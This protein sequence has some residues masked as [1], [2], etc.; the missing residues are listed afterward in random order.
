MN[1]TLCIGNATYKVDIHYNKTMYRLLDVN[2]RIQHSGWRPYQKQAVSLTADAYYALHKAG[3]VD[4]SIMVPDETPVRIQWMGDSHIITVGSHS[5]NVSGINVDCLSPMTSEM[6]TVYGRL[7]PLLELLRQF[8]SKTV[9]SWRG[10]IGELRD[11]EHIVASG[12]FNVKTAINMY[13]I[14]LNTLLISG[15]LVQSN[16]DVWLPEINHRVRYESPSAI[17]QYAR[18]FPR[19]ASQLYKQEFMY[20]KNHIHKGNYDAIWCALYNGLSSAQMV[21][22]WFAAQV[23]DVQNVLPRIK[24]A[25]IPHHQAVIAQC[26]MIKELIG[27]DIKKMNVQQFTQ[28][29]KKHKKQMHHN[30]INVHF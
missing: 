13:G 9:A 24:D 18:I 20:Y 26:D 25:L 3:I 12:C 4:Y 27:P 8:S 22:L 2:E 21:M 28:Y 6:L 5:I 23:S 19:E 17:H 1:T 29:L 11:I 10:T 15:L 7:M 14:S 16:K 30:E